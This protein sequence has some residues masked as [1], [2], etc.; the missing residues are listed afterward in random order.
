MKKLIVATIICLMAS[1]ASAGDNNVYA[2]VQNGPI[3]IWCIDGYKFV[4]HNGSA[5]V[6]IFRQTAP[7][8]NPNV[9]PPQ[10]VKCNE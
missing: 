7:K 9:Y 1:I 10:P 8:E 4:S 6:Q 5:L 2:I 3:K